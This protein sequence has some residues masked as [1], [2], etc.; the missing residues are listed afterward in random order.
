MRKGKPRKI[1]MPPQVGQWYVHTPFIP[2][3]L[4]LFPV[5]P[6]VA[7]VTFPT[8]KKKFFELNERK[9]F[10]LHNKVAQGLR[11]RSGRSDS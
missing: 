3:P 1:N 10:D 8:F 2:L 5:P 11:H 9:Y 4:S 6:A 7:A